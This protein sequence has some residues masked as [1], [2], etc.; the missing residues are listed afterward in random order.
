MPI[1]SIY[2]SKRIR[3]LEVRPLNDPESVQKPW[4]I[5]FDGI[6]LLRCLP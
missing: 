6:H 1:R 3:P 5:P 4:G 2:N